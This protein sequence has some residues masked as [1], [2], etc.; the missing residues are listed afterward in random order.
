MYRNNDSCRKI[1]DHFILETKTEG[2]YP[3]SCFNHKIR[4]KESAK[5]F[6][7][8]KASTAVKVPKEID[9]A[10]IKGEGNGGEN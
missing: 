3:S 2:I 7:G 1:S 5:S 10:N 6:G 9:V 4:T 8:I